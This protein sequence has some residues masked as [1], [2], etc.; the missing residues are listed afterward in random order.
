MDPAPAGRHVHEETVQAG[1]GQVSVQGQE[2]QGVIAPRVK[3]VIDTKINPD[4][5]EGI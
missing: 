2:Q 5:P 4:P 3:R 1:C